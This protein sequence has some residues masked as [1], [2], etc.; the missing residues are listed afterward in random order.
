MKLDTRIKM[1]ETTS[2]N[3]WENNNN[4]MIVTIKSVGGHILYVHMQSS[5]KWNVLLHIWKQ[6]SLE[7]KITFLHS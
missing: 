1:Y 4:L 3:N 2:G 6:L 5:V 7:M